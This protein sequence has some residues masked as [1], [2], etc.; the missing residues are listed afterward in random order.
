MPAPSFLLL[1]SLALT[2]LAIS[3]CATVPA[4]GGLADVQRLTAQRLPQHV[5]W[6]AGLAEDSL[7]QAYVAR[8]LHGEMPVDS[9]IQVALLRNRAL[10]A[11][12]EEL[13]LAQADVVQ[14]GLLSNPIF[15]G[16]SLV[17]RGGGR[18]VQLAGIA[19]PFIDALQRPLRK[20]VAER[21]FAAAR[22]RVANAVLSLAASVR[23]AYVDAQSAEQMVEMRA[24]VVQATEASASTAA[25]L[26]AAG[27]L[28]D[29]A[30]AQERALAADARLELIHADE[31]SQVAR[32]ELE[33][34]MGI[35]ADSRQSF[36]GGRP[37]C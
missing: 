3:A 4:R 33:R 36:G 31:A 19:W 1:P 32:A 9:A 29:L 2:A 13:G 37:Y 15:S 8:Q 7:G 35:A 17:Q 21:D 30:L 10:Q 11:T 22:A 28:S 18:G 26:L 14:A 6:Q 24:T 34:S 12:F 5:V 16:E 27:N 23:I 20:R 25:A